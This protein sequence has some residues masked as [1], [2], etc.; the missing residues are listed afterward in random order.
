L[1]RQGLYSGSATAKPSTYA[2]KLITAPREGSTGKFA[3][4]RAALQKVLTGK[5]KTVK[6]KTTAIKT[7]R[8][9]YFVRKHRAIVEVNKG[10]RAFYSKPKGKVIRVGRIDTGRYTREKLEHVPADIN[11]L[12][13]L[14]AN[15]KFTIPFNRGRFGTDYQN[16][17]RADLIRLVVEYE[18]SKK[19]IDMR[20]FIEITTYEF[21]SANTGFWIRQRGRQFDLMSGKIMI[22]TFST[23]E[24]AEEALEMELA[25]SDDEF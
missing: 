10:E 19:W 3:Q 25:N 15:Q 22:A 6:I 12:R 23:R 9:Q 20:D 18:K 1:K 16:F 7:V 2:K 11:N 5:A 13:R 8:D 14:K 4:A 17:T 24:E 21:V